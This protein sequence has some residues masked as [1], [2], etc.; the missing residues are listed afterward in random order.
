MLVDINHITIRI[1]EHNTC[2]ACSLFVGLA[3]E[4]NIIIFQLTLNLPYVIEFFKVLGILI[5][6]GIEGQNI[7]LKHALKQT[8]KGMFI[9]HNEVIAA[10]VARKNGK[11]QLLIKCF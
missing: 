4:R 7:V 10:D 3:T 1:A 6:A 11:T 5:P 2:R 9:F 8:D